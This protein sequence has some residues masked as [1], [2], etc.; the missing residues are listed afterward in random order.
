[1]QCG[2]H[3]CKAARPAA[4]NPSEPQHQQDMT[5]GSNDNEFPQPETVLA[6]RGAI[7]L[8]LRGG[9]RGP[10]GLW[11]NEFWEMG[12]AL[13]DHN[14]ALEGFQGRVVD[15]LLGTSYH[16]LQLKGPA[17]GSANA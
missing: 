11:L 8:G 4:E 12:R 15:E 5:T 2:I 16:Y 1:M 17:F 14:A 6:I 13:R 7:S 10:D 9:P 3:R